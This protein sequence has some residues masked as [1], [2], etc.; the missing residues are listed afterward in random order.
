MSI[1][2]DL[3]FLNKKKFNDLDD[4]LRKEILDSCFPGIKNWLLTT[5]N[6]SNH[7]DL[8]YQAKKNIIYI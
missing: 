8:F 1:C 3:S 6:N 7:R 4:S 5:L 2:R